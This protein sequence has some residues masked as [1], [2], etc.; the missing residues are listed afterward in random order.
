MDIGQLQVGL[1]K[2]FFRE[3]HRIV[4]WYDAEQ[5]FVDDI[6]SLDLKDVK[7]IDMS[8]ESSLGIKLLLEIDD[9][10]GKYLL[11]FPSKEPNIEDDW[12]LDIKFYSRM[13][14][15]D[16]FSIIFNDLGL[17]Q[18]SLKD[19]LIK[20]QKFLA[21]KARVAA[22]KRHTFADM[23]EIELDL[24]MIASIV[25]SEQADL[26]NI[27]F[28][29]ADEFVEEDLGLSS[30]PRSFV[31]LEKYDLLST[32]LDC[33]KLQFGY[34]SNLKEEFRLGR[35][36]ISLLMTDFC[37]DLGEIPT[38]SQNL[39]VPSNNYH[40]TI[41]ALLSRW[42]DSL[43][44]YSSLDHISELVAEELKIADK[45]ATLNI[46]DIQDIMAFSQID[47]HIMIDLVLAIP[48][49]SIKELEYFQS[50]IRVRL[51]GYWAS[52]DKNTEI[53]SKY[54][55][56]YAALRA[57]IELFI[58]RHVFREG[59]H[60]SSCESLYKAYEKEIYQI[61]MTYRHYCIASKDAQV[62]L[63]KDLDRDI[64]ECYSHWYIDHLAKNWGDNLESE[65]RL[66][67][68]RIPGI[69]NQYNF[70]ASKVEPLLDSSN[71]RRVV[72]IISD[73]LRYEAAVEL[74]ERI[75]HKR[76]SEATLSSQLG[77]VPSYT[78][79]G[80]ASL[81][82]HKTLEYKNNTDDVLLDGLSTQGTEARSRI[83][84]VYGGFAVTAE[85][86]KN[87][88]R[89]EGRKALKDKNLVYVYH[90]V[91]DARGDSA[92]TESET[93]A[94]VE[95]AINELND[96]SRKIMMHFNTSTVLITADHGFLFQQGKLSDA[97][98]SLLI[99]KPIDT[100]KS[101][102]RYLIGSN[103]PD[104]QEA[105]K[106][107]IKDT[108]NAN[109]ETEFWIP[110][111]ANRFHF[112]GGSRFVH[113]GVMP[114]EIVVPIITIKQLRG[115]DAQK[116]TASKVDVISLKSTWKM[117]N[118]IQRFDFMQTESIGEFLL[119]VTVSIAIYDGDTKVSSE[120]VVTFDSSA[121][122]DADRKKQ[123]RLSLLGNDFDRKKEYFLLLKD[124]EL[125]TE[126][127]RYKVTIDLA[128]TDDFF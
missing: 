62:E 21:N 47:R 102:K 32:L 90:N 123:V 9:Q 103:L 122:V 115:E 42:R 65:Q 18:L 17:K 57:A 25:K 76:Y 55:I 104:T 45:I 61:D 31:E 63:L 37:G 72:V 27:L 96:L 40:A 128:F 114:Q 75:N 41:K 3:N 73:A 54:Q 26:I 110:K 88:D 100:I 70:Y 82:P 80:M 6:N 86:V 5:S 20:R 15:A 14:Y 23:N 2:A 98:K 66:K 35:F 30:N 36:F 58:L 74:C 101:K 125:E 22:L 4:F 38:W 13:F 28:A 124:K 111:G 52:T 67:E 119:P 71:R 99:E 51:D 117:V 44:Y 81:L 10:V 8:K 127:G 48:K 64:E 33:L 19:H 94:A 78:T 68:W 69:P 77:V 109:S 85:T 126:I 84:S 16:R 91:I 59:F 113:G 1:E 46:Q 43:K 116:R 97:D 56:I 53:R 29:L 87:W 92:S 118:N 95:D 11:Y 49:A 107:S 34:I 12:L 7:I 50:Y 24:A 89:A 106:G 83:L 121:D 39:I 108:A 79:L 120:E 60:F 112:I 105:W 93:F